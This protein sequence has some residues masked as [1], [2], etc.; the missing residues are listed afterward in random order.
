[1]PTAN[2]SNLLAELEARTA[3]RTQQGDGEAFS[4]D[5]VESEQEEEEEDFSNLLGHKQVCTPSP[6]TKQGG[7]GQ[8]APLTNPTAANTNAGETTPAAATFTL[9]TPAQ[10]QAKGSALL[11]VLAEIDRG[12]SPAQRKQ[13]FQ[14]QANAKN[15]HLIFKDKACAPSTKLR[16]YGFATKNSP[17]IKIVHSIGKYYGED[18][19][20]LQGTTIGFTGDRTENSNPSAII[21]PELNSWNWKK[22]TIC[23]DRVR[24]ATFYGDPTNRTKKWDP[25]GLG[26][27]EVEL[28]R[29]IYLT[30]M[31]AAWAAQEERTFYEL[32]KYN[33]ELV[34]STE[35][36]GMITAEDVALH[37]RWC[38]AMCQLAGA[39]NLD[40][41]PAPVFTQDQSF[42]KWSNLAINT[43]LGQPTSYATPPAQHE[44]P[45]NAPG[46]S[47]TAVAA[48]QTELLRE[49]MQELRD[50]HQ[51]Q[52]SNSATTSQSKDAGGKLYSEYQIAAIKGFS[53]TADVTQ[54]SPIWT[55]FQKT[56]D[57]DDQRCILGK[58]MAEWSKV[59]GIE[60]DTGVFYNK[61]TMEDIVKV[62]P[63]SAEGL[64]TLKTG[65]RGCS[66]LSCFPR[67]P[68]EIEALRI[69]EQAARVSQAN[70]TFEEALKL[71]Q[72]DGRA[73]PDNYMETRLTIATYAA[74]LWSLWTKGCHHYE[75]VMKVYNTL[76]LPEVSVIKGAFTP[77]H[78]RE[79]I[80]AI[81]DDGRRFFSKRKTPSE[82]AMPNVAWPMS[83]LGDIMLDVTFA[84]RIERPGFPTSWKI[85][86][87]AQ[88][89]RPGATGS[90]ELGTPKSASRGSN[91]EYGT[92]G[93][94]GGE[95]LR[96]AAKPE[97]PAVDLREL[98]Q[99][100]EHVHKDIREELKDVHLKY[101]GE[102]KLTQIL[103]AAGDKK[104]DDLP[105]IAEL[106]NPTTGKN[107]L[108]YN[109]ICGRCRFGNKCHRAVMGGHV[110]ANRLTPD[111]IGALC[112]LLRPGIKWVVTNGEPYRARANKR[113]F[114]K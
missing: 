20:E 83:L 109:Y 70:H 18:D 77:I 90:L 50:S 38:L 107:D 3:E 35:G 53:G 92:L 65:E 8:G 4:Q 78:C 21:L 76:C 113:K 5:N 14:W 94:A 28:P 40:L 44:S 23:S 84:R 41:A 48:A 52:A 39:N 22:V 58:Y 51:Q 37:Q 114:G 36:G 99:A 30:T 33:D 75:M 46:D 59:M 43:T 97:A 82:L 45:N 31:Q 111:F 42:H 112:K 98:G 79:L 24:A 16:C 56:K 49:M 2:R 27:E 108:C 17:Y 69:K 7:G 55:Q 63:N 13:E 93:V 62:R 80:W 103:K 64:A 25:S 67:A 110:E 68:M 87:P 6:Y 89:E 9:A 96:L 88:D 106:C 12:H 105:K 1:M 15:L 100:L 54:L 86:L 19:S 85:K 81:Y 72:S 47:T 71:A 104:H 29:L 91:A 60:I 11:R 61:E 73:P 101:N 102:S 26:T 74:E 34:T 32:Y 95:P 66:I 57:I 10:C